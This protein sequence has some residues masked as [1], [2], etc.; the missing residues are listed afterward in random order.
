[1]STPLMEMASGYTTYRETHGPYG[2]IVKGR[3]ST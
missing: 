1:M 3:S 2:P